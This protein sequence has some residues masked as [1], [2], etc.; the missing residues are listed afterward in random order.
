MN[1]ANQYRPT[2][3][4]DVIGQRQAVDVLS[5][6]AR[7]R[8]TRNVLLSGAF[9][10]GKTSMARILAHAWNCANPTPLGSPCG[11]CDYCSGRYGK[12]IFECTVTAMAGD[13]SEICAIL[14]NWNRTPADYPVQTMFFDEA[15]GLQQSGVEALLNATEEPLEGVCFL[16]ATTKPW[17]LPRAL[18]SRLFEVT[19]NSVN[20]SDSMTLLRRT[21][22]KAKLTFDTDALLLLSALKRGHSRDLISGLEQISL[23]VD[24]ITS[25]VVKRRFDIDQEDFL[26]DYFVA[27]AMGDKAKQNHVMREWQ[28]PLAAKIGW[29]RAYLLSMYHRDLLSHDISVDPIVDTMMRSRSEIVCSFCERLRLDDPRKLQPYWRRWLSFWFAPLSTDEGLLRLRLTLFEDVVNSGFTDE[30]AADHS[31]AAAYRHSNI[32]NTDDHLTQAPC[33]TSNAEVSRASDG[34]FCFG[35]KDLTLIVNR[36]SFYAQHHGCYMNA[37]LEVTPAFVAMQDDAGAIAVITRFAHDLGRHV[38]LSGEACAVITVFD[39][40]ASGITGKLLVH[41]PDLAL[42]KEHITAMSSWCDQ[43]GRE[44]DGGHHI[45]LVVAPSKSIRRFHWRAIAWMAARTHDITENRPGGALGIAQHLLETFKIEPDEGYIGHLP[46]PPVMFSDS[47]SEHAIDR[48]CQLDMPLLSAIDDGAL[49]WLTNGWE[50]V[51]YAERSR[52]R[53]SR[54]RDMRN[55][56]DSYDDIDEQTA[57]REALGSEWH[58]SAKSRPRKSTRWWWND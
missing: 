10:S 5:G 22:A 53:I 15:H 40:E 19:V 14:K 8:K 57:A 50:L 41:A 49:S 38:G 28:E 24:H 17:L 16:F 45:K 47:L 4:E 2:K 52:T 20:Q 6:L 39:K 3:F 21:A 31:S 9:G 33:M 26:T 37:W 35:S 12:T 27:L 42:G 34:K 7:R 43:W 46:R 13:A 11:S 25:D 56:D 30:P 36:A 51:E 58:K 1:F 44:A 18:K 32:N 29:I 55:I 48:A 23:G 54:A